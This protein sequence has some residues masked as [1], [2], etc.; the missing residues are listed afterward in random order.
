MADEWIELTPEQSAELDRLAV[1]A[2]RAG[3]AEPITDADLDEPDKSA[4]RKD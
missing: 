3:G 2:I 4:G 1:E